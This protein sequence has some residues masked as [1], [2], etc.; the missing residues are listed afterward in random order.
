MLA[1][2]GQSIRAQKTQGYGQPI[3]IYREDWPKVKEA[4]GINPIYI[5]E[6]TRKGRP[7]KSFYWTERSGWYVMLDKKRIKLA[8]GPN[9]PETQSIAS[10][11]LQELMAE[12]DI[13]KPIPT[14]DNATLIDNQPVTLPSQPSEE[15]QGEKGPSWAE[16]TGRKRTGRSRE[17]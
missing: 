4:A 14:P 13:E 9:T 11:L 5:K 12:R 16:K 2:N 17:E 8:D 6:P 7:P 1:Y 3:C 15:N 10:Q